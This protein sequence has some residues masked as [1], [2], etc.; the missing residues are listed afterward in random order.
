ML[1]T[2]ISA[3]Q[4]KKIQVNINFMNKPTLPAKWSKF[5]LRVTGVVC[6]FWSLKILREFQLDGVFLDMC[7]LKILCWAIPK[8]E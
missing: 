8:L 5:Q 2:G 6:S 3:L 4:K 1:H 7:C